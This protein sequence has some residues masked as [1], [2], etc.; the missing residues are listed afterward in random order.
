LEFPVSLKSSYFFAG[1]SVFC[2]SHISEIIVIIF[3][4]QSNAIC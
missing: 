4:K 2:P 3:L 1:A